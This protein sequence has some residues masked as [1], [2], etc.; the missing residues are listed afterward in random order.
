MAKV[1]SNHF[2]SF[3]S[4]PIIK[5]SPVANFGDHPLAFMFHMLFL[6][7]RLYLIIIQYIFFF[8]GD[9]NWAY[10][11]FF[12]R[13]KRVIFHGKNGCKNACGVATSGYDGT[14]TKKWWS[15]KK[16]KKWFLTIKKVRKEFSNFSC[17]FLNP[18]NFFQFEL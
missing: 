13:I 18:N 6:I 10:F 9:M 7:F 15:S 3:W 5:F 16:W 8:D 14:G 4:M 17:R 2:Y 11:S 1:Q 12:F